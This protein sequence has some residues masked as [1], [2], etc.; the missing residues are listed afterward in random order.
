MSQTSPD[1]RRLP[2]L[3]FGLYG[4]LVIFDHVDKTIK[5]VANADVKKLGGV[6]AGTPF[7]DPGA[8][9]S[10]REARFGNMG[11]NALRGWKWYRCTRLK[12]PISRPR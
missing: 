10:V 9:A 12:E 3:L 6:G 2:D 11:L 8:F 7:Y 4:E 1:D 5:V